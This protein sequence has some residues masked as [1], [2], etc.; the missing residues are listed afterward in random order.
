MLSQ[1]SVNSLFTGRTM[2]APCARRVERPWGA[3]SAVAK[4]MNFGVKTTLAVLALLLGLCVPA[5]AGPP[6]T[7][8]PVEVQLPS[9]PDVQPAPV[10]QIYLVAYR[11]HG[12]PV[13]LVYVST[14]GGVVGYPTQ[15]E[16]VVMEPGDCCIFDRMTVHGSGPNG[17][18]DPRL[19]YAVQ[20]HRSDTK[21]FVD[22]TWQ[23]LT[24]RPRWSAGPVAAFTDAAQRGE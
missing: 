17:S 5:H 15:W 22:G 14:M 23:A 6:L 16:D 21:A 19:A 11:A 2:T 12:P 4:T 13:C 3:W 18:A 10:I 24:E 9:V 7:T 1:P 20:F 8:Q